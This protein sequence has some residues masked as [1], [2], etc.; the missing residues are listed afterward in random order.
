MTLRLGVSALICPALALSATY[1][2]EQYSLNRLTEAI[3]DSLS[4]H[5]DLT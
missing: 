1:R 4:T 3:D 5:R 2:N